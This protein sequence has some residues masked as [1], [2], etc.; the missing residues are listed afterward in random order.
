MNQTIIGDWTLQPIVRS[1]GQAERTIGFFATR[2]ATAGVEGSISAI[3]FRRPATGNIGWQAFAWTTI[4]N[5]AEAFIG[6]VEGIEPEGTIGFG[7]GGNAM[8]GLD[9]MMAYERGLLAGDPMLALLDQSN[10]EA[11]LQYLT[12][13]GYPAAVVPFDLIPGVETT[14]DA[15]LNMLAGES[16]FLAAHSSDSVE[17][18]AEALRQREIDF[19]ELGFEN[20]WPDNEP[21]V[22]CYDRTVTLTT[23]GC[24]AGHTCTE[25]LGCVWKNEERTFDCTF[26]RYE[27]SAEVRVLVDRRECTDGTS[28][29][30]APYKEC[31]SH[32]LTTTN[33]GYGMPTFLTPCR[34]PCGGG[35][36]ILSSPGHLTQRTIPHGCH[37]LDV[38]DQVSELACS[39]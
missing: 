1:E 39:F 5:D 17:A 33:S 3:W 34:A 38:E 13:A 37:V 25:S 24:L 16:E 12:S 28:T 23:Y 21:L 2:A 19:E 27:T 18:M 4:S 11:I 30:S 15:V 32:T 9:G 6:E 35:C 14:N 8:A 22:V 29:Q 7:G 26:T 10:R 20:L 36:A 31:R